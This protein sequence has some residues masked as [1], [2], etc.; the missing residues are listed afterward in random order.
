MSPA[1]TLGC[2]FFGERDRTGAESRLTGLSPL[3]S[4]AT[5]SGTWQH[6]IL[7]EVSSTHSQAP[8]DKIC[9]WI[10][11]KALF[12]PYFSPRNS[13]FSLSS[14]KAFKRWAIKVKKGTELQTILAFY[15]CELGPFRS[16][17]LTGILHTEKWIVSQHWENPGGA[18]ASSELDPGL[19]YVIRA[20][21]SS[22][23]SLYSLLEYILWWLYVISGYRHH[24]N[25]KTTKEE[26]EVLYLRMTKKA[27]FI[28][29]AWL[30]R[31]QFHSWP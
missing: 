30:M 15:F 25:F 26:N 11:E 24:F 9:F 13:F 18:L 12:S 14:L 6:Q 10:L 27:N 22:N 4:L 23:L 7:T 20:W 5:S 29:L 28:A 8:P 21:F 2:G 31:L 17:E 19:S 3:L 16:S 1:S